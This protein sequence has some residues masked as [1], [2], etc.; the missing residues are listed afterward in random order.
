[1]HGSLGVWAPSAA[2]SAGL[3]AALRK[4][5]NVLTT[6]VLPCLAGAAA[7]TVHNAN[8][9]PSKLT[10]SKDWTHDADPTL[11]ARWAKYAGRTGAGRIPAVSR[12][13]PRRRI[14]QA[15]T[16]EVTPQRGF[17]GRHP[18]VAAIGLTTGGHVRRS[19]G[20]RRRRAWPGRTAL[21]SSPWRQPAVRGLF[22]PRRSRSS[23]PGSAAPGGVRPGARSR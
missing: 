4:V 13:R 9:T 16:G 8:L 11:I 23:A 18:R 6:T 1:M 21:R 7:C 3:G 19:R 17:R 22:S 12:A 10:E 15:Y 5:L 14:S 20:G 2:M